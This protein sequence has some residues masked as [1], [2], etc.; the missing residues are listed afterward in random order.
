MNNLTLNLSEYCL[1]VVDEDAEIIRGNL[2]LPD[3][4]RIDSSYFKPCYIAA[5]LCILTKIALDVDRFH[6]KI[7]DQLILLTAMIDQQ[8]G[9]LQFNGYRTF[10]E[11]YVLNTS[12]HL[13]LKEITYADLGSSPSDELDT[14]VNKFLKK[15]QT[16][17]LVLMN[18]AY[19]IW[20][21]DGRYY[22]FDPYPCDEKGKAN[23]DGY[24]CLMRFRDFKPMLDKI[25]ENAGETAEKPFRL[26]TVTIAHIKIKKRKRKRKKD[27]EHRAKLR[28]LLEESVEIKSEET[29]PT[30][31]SEKSLIEL[32]DWVTSGPELDLHRDIA[33]VG[34]TPMRHYEVSMLEVIVLE[35]DITTP[36]LAPFEKPSEIDQGYEETKERRIPPERIFRNH[37][38]I[39]IPI[40][41]CIMAWSLIHDPASWSERTIDG[42]FE[43]AIDYAFDS[44]LA[45]EDTSVS[46]MIDAVLPEFEIANYVFRAV[47]APLHYGTLYA[48]EGWNLTMTLEKIFETT[49]YTGAIIVCG[50]AHVGVTKCGKNY[51]AWWTVTGTKNLRMIASNSLSEFLKVI[52][53]VIGEPEKIRFLVRAI[54][55]SYARKMAP[56]FSDIKGLHESTM[57]TPSLAEIHC[58]EKSYDIQAI[59]KMIGPALDPIFISGTVALRDRDSLQEPRM[60]RCYFVALLAVIIK[61]DI[62][63]SPLPGMIDRILEVA[64]SL[65]RG[66]FEPK[67]HAEQI[68][69]NV[70]LMN[71]LF[72]LRD[73]ASPLVVLTTNSQTGKKDFYKQVSAEDKDKNY[74]S[75]VFSFV[76]FYKNRIILPILLS[77][78]LSDTVINYFYVF[79]ILCYFY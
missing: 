70:S 69:R 22:F 31:E 71:R 50:Y 34:F 25:K 7:L 15:Y 6:D 43:A 51:F 77:I 75:Y 44:V 3:R 8:I 61:R 21:A 29:P 72:D 4:T 12:F 60:K 35:N 79:M 37:S 56:D 30:V 28:K 55:I 64:E 27:I 52:V 17:I 24:C 40:D 39:A 47:F 59:F 16:G 66:F 32:A 68:L 65:Y 41:L 36:K 49:I 74:S 46:D 5:I 53:K 67:F 11:V 63:Q 54:T 9:K 45:N 48:T 1:K 2:N 78:I 38:S 19:P 26:Y 13:I 73:C 23:E 18:C 33:I 57:A 62:V 20:T 58:K 14:V 76:Y 42:L 10:D